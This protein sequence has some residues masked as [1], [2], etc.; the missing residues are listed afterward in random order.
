MFFTSKYTPAPVSMRN[1]L[2]VTVISLIYLLLSAFLVGYKSD[3]VVLVCLFNAMYYISK[4]TRRFI[5]GFSIFIVYWIIFDYMKIVPNYLFKGVDIGGIYNT[6]KAWFGIHTSTGVVTPN[7]FFLQH[8]MPFVDIL[9]GVFYLTWVPVPLAFAVYLFFRQRREF[10]YF[11]LTFLLVNI[12]GFVIYY[13]HPA[14]P[15][16]YVE[17]FGFHFNPHTPGNTAGLARFDHLTGTEIFKSIYQKSSNV[18]AAMPSLHSSYPVIV[19]FYAFR[20]KLGIVRYLFALVMLGIWF[21]AVYNSHHYVL[22]VLA[23]ILCA[24][25]GIWLFLQLKGQKW[26][27]RWLDR[28]MQITAP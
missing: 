3:Q 10:F 21:S 24:I 4:D 26:L 7:E 16:W 8:S 23:G 18:F 20:N 28:M 22:D 5:I 9:T 17:Q 11:S 6:E 14:A 19:L 12:I 1:I 13:L 25:F 2:W 27:S 15:P